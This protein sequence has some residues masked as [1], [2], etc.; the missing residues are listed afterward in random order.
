MLRLIVFISLLLFSGTVPA[1]QYKGVTLSLAEG[2]SQ[3]SVYDIIQDHEG[4]TWMAT[5]DG[6]NRFDGK[7]FKIYREEPF[8]TN[9]ISSNYISDLMSDS[10]GRIWVGTANNGLNLLLPG[11]EIFKR[12]V[13]DNQKGSLSSNIITDL[14]E[15]A[16]GTIWVGTGNGLYKLTESVERDN[17]VFNFERIPLL[18]SAEDTNTEKYVSE[19]INDNKQQL[20]VGTYTGLFKLNICKDAISNSDIVWFGKQNNKLSD[21]VIHALTLDNA[22]R[23]WAGGRNGID[24]FNS[25]GERIMIL[26]TVENAQPGMKSNQVSSLYSASNGD[27]WV[28]YFDNGVQ[29]VKNAGSDDELSFVSTSTTN[30]LPVLEKGHTVSIW[31]DKISEGII[32]VGFNAGGSVR[33]VPVTKKFV[34]NNLADAPISS[35]FVINILSSNGN[36]WIGT[37]SG[38]LKFNKTDKT[39]SKFLPSQIS[40]STSL[41]NYINGLVF[42]KQGDVLFGSGNHLFRIVEKNE[43][44]YSEQIMIPDFITRDRNFLR[45]IVSDKDQNIYLVFRYSVYRFDSSNETFEKVI[46]TSDQVKLNDK[47]FYF[48]SYFVDL[49]GN[50]WL[51][52]SNG[53]EFFAKQGANTQTYFSKS[54]TYKHNRLDTSSLRN[55]NILCIS[56][57]IAGNV[58]VGTMNGL[59]RVVD[60]S[61]ERKF[62]NYSTK[63][64]LKNNVIY[65]IIPDT[66][67]GHLWLS[68]NNGLI[69]F[70]PKGFA[71][72]TYDVHDG[73]QSNEFNSYAAFKSDK[74]EMFFGGIAGYTSFYPDQIIRDHTLPWISISNIVLDGNR[75]INLSDNQQSKTIDLKYRD[76]SFTVNF[77]GLHYVD[78]QKIQYAY[79]LEGFQSDWTSAGASGS[80]NFSQLPPGKYVFKVKASNSD[81]VFNEAGDMFV[82]NINPPFYKT[83]WFYLLIAAAIAAIIYGLFKYRL[84]MK[85]AQVREVEKIRKATAADFHDE[86]GHK[87]TIISW[88]AEIL[89]KKIGPEQTELRPHL[90][91]IIEASG[92]LYH[93]MKD[94]LWAMD[95]DKD[96]VYD[97]YNQIKEFGQELFDNTGIEFEAAD[98]PGALKSNII[99]PAHKR[100]V[101]LIFKEVMHNS[102]KHANG[103]TTALEIEMNGSYIKF[104]FRDNGTG[105]K[106][107]GH[108]IG[109]G[110][111]NVKRRAQQIQAVI[112]INSE[113]S[114][115]VAE[116]DL[117]YEHLN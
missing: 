38:L 98:I 84:S 3:S 40:K 20:W 81:G 115:T 9:S 2:L 41:D 62:L 48:S 17:S 59:T 31:E 50:H 71:V 33:L 39:Y 58:W 66:K 75:E 105:F 96:S 80:V 104:R 67:T 60:D 85:M 22:G 74:G 47:G 89:K 73:L 79:L 23:I 114:G 8:D 116:L 46:V 110:L 1:Q 52:T 57:D 101:L 13:A 54:V 6:L 100:H 18:I 43:R 35:S 15:D 97:L 72:A 108:G 112:K 69:E 16:G 78:P 42:T 117:A 86:L 7:S 87:L 109:R 4:Y 56:E 64:G 61:G 30:V 10:K 5:Q 51:G 12:F 29:V 63:D 103:N 102:L 94:M 53:L 36:D 76:N 92:N 77:A 11:K 45:T 24:V 34:T 111:E 88:F 32:W 107:N 99:S 28:G 27:V 83:I 95:P 19:I 68:T 65:A 26:S 113:N 49:T 25:N 93:T 14:H 55:H 44:D 82:I 106:L 21:R 90:D 37:N 70:D 91:R